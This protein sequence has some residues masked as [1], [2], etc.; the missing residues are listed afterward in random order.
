MPLKHSTETLLVILL[1]IVTMLTGVA[2]AVLPS[3]SL[4][5]VP[6]AILFAATLAY[7]LALYPFFR[8]RRADYAFR[9]LHLA[10]ALILIIWLALSFLAPGRPLIQGMKHW[11]TWG[12]SLPAVAIVFYGLLWF[13]LDVIRQRG[14]RITAITVLFFVFVASA[15][16]GEQQHLPSLLAS[17]L[18]PSSLE[19]AGSGLVIA[20]VSNSQANLGASA[21]ISEEAYRAKLRRMQRRDHRLA[22]EKPAMQPVLS[23]TQGAI[24]AANIPTVSERAA[25][26]H[27][28]SP[29]HL[30]SSGPSFELL[31]LTCIGVYCAAV[32]R[33]A[34]LRMV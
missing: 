3:P 26:I 23:A 28:V 33:R 30:P 13:C 29:L 9:L 8:E 34:T 1:A 10:P 4:H 19:T 6:W 7:P 25:R 31:L 22:A 20:H 21:S 18:Q 32:H 2:C 11:Y 16:A 5:P 24:A 17:V 12:W 27:H 14:Q 15:I